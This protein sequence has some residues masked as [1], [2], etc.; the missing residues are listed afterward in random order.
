[1]DAADQTILHA[2]A[3]GDWVSG[4]ALASDLGL[5][6]TALAKRIAHLQQAPCKLPIHSRH[7]RGYRLEGGL[8]LLTQPNGQ[9]QAAL[10]AF[11]GL[12][13][14]QICESTNALLQ[15]DPQTQILLAEFQS[16]GRGR[17]N[18]RW[19]A[20]FAQSLLL[21]LRHRYPVWPAHLPSLG[22]VLGIAVVQAL[23]ALD[24]PARLKWPNDVWLGERKLAGL[25]VESRGEALSSCEL[26]V[27][28]GLNVHLRQAQDIDQPWTSLRRE[29]LLLRRAELG[30]ALITAL[31]AAL[32]AFPHI[33][34]EQQLEPLG[35]LDACR[36]RPILV[37]DGQSSLEGWHAGFGPQGALRLRTADGAIREF[38]VGDVSL[39]PA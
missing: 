37:R 13:L 25:L 28:L 39:R 21:S 29:G 38:V 5:S 24:V 36:D 10:Q 9:P 16:A 18:R 1:M 26:V 12:K 22:L 33:P 14:V 35:Q 30:A 34:L 20:P 6:R 19:Q 27:G 4:S 8:D 23:R 15:A 32:E 7:G 11:K 2:L 17:L 3:S 31:Q